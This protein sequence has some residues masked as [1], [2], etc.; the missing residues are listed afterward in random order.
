L[1]LRVLVL[2]IIVFFLKVFQIFFNILAP[3]LLQ[4]FT[5]KYG[6]FLLQNRHFMEVY[7]IK[8]DFFKKWSKNGAKNIYEKNVHFLL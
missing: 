6:H 8:N 7:L 5:P 4:N 1:S 2:K 3:F